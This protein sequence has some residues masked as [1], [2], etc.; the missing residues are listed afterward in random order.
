MNVT[1]EFIED[2]DYIII[3]FLYKQ[4]TPEHFPIMFLNICQN[5]LIADEQLRKEVETL[6]DITKQVEK[7]ATSEHQD[8][9]SEDKIELISKATEDKDKQSKVKNE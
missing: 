3:Q 5:F 6:L 4:Y 1:K 9:R 8:T 7:Q 2:K